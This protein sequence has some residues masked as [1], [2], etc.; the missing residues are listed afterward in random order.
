MDSPVQA[1][2]DRVVVIVKEEVGV[3]IGK[4]CFDGNPNR[5]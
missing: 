2:A 3:Y 4:H 1:S 5:P